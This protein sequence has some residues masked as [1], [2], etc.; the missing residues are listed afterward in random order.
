M[1]SR[2]R[3]SLVVGV[4]AA[5]ALAL[6][7]CGTTGGGSATPSAQPVKTEIGPGEG[8]LSILGWPGYVEDGSNDPAVDWVTPFE[9][10]TGCKVSFKPFGTSDEAVTLMRTGQY[11]VVSA[12]GDASLRLIAGNDVEPVNMSL[13]KN[14]PDVYPFLKDKA[15]NTVDGKN[16]GM[17]HGWG[18]NLLMYSVDTVTPAPTSW[19]AVFDDAAQHSGKVTAY[20]S[21]IYIADAAVYLMA[22]KPELGIKN[23]YALD[24][25]QLAASVELLK[26]QRQHVGEYWSDVV[27][28]VQAFASGSTVVGTTWQVGANIAVDERDQCGDP[29]PRRGRHRLVGHVDDRFGVQEQELRLP[30]ARL[31]RQPRGQRGGGGVLRRIAGQPQGLR[32][33][34]GQGA[35]RDLPL[36][37]RGLRGADLV[38][39]HPGGQMPGRPHR[40]QVHGLLGVDEGLDRDQGLTMTLQTQ[41]PVPGAPPAAAAVPRPKAHRFSALLHRSPNLRLAGLVTAPAG[42]LVL[43]YI[44]AL[45]ALLITAFWTVDTFTGKVSTEWTTENVVTVLTDP[46]Y[47]RI[48]L[49][50]L[51]IAIAVTLIDLVLALPMAFFIAKVASPRW[52]KL[53]VVAVLMPLWASYLVKAYAWRNV[54]ADGGLLEWLGAPIGLESPGYGETAVI[55]TL[56][57]IWLPFM[58]LPIYAGF[59]RV[60]DSL[61]EA[62]GDLGAKP[63]TT[64]RLV[65]FPLLVPSIIA[66]TIFTFSLSLGDYI[67]A[68]IVGG[69]TQMLGTVVYANVG[70]ANNLPFAAAVSLVPIAI[71]TLY[72]FI[73]RR[74]G[75]LNSL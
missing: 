70:A 5:A 72:L 24:K 52:Q 67:T 40:R 73:V 71:I 29:A 68:Q 8:Q 42:W 38:L 61:L 37:R 7:G 50:T 18:A 13:L 54:L 11:D 43:V 33:D 34:Q 4:A 22:H 16:Y 66:G 10:Q 26:Q 21:P 65:M 3:A 64:M 2:N 63:L 20:D 60:P 23:P 47:Q 48:T 14:Y 30:V 35:L 44:A 12:S 56:A 15:W 75:A 59:D 74:S 45:A 51:W 17:P 69:T 39:D 28:E 36:R 53:L 62:S 46:V 31:H 58:I 41:H 9:T 49:R 1:A 57:Y 27:K 6:A 32:P 55:L 25:D 19:R